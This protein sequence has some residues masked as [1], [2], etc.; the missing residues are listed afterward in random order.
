VK[1]VAAALFCWWAFSMLAYIV[2][3]IFGR[4]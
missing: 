1:L 4:R 2:Q 3:D